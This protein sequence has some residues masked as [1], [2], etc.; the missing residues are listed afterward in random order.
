VALRPSSARRKRAVFNVQG[1]VGGDY[2]SYIISHIS[3]F[4]ECGAA[5]IR[6]SSHEYEK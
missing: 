3:Y 4:I 5:H 6:T 2:R 1:P